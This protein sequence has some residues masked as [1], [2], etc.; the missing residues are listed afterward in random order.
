[1]LRRVAEKLQFPLEEVQDSQHKLLDIL[2]RK[3]SSQIALPVNEAILEP[4]RTEWHIPVR[5]APTPK[6]M[7]KRYFVP[8]KEVEFLFSDPASDSLVIQTATKRSSQQLP[9]ATC[10]DKVVKC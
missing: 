3:E 10:A 4:A 1:M 2:Q 6:R 8:A 5:C 7:E 9:R